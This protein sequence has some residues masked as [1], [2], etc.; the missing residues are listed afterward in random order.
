VFRKGHGRGVDAQDQCRTLLPEPELPKFLHLAA[1][2]G[3][4]PLIYLQSMA[5]NGQCIRGRSC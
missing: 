5:N 4:L 3:S 1:L 2:S